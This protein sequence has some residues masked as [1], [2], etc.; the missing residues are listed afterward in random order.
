MASVHRNESYH[1]FVKNMHF[2]LVLS[3]KNYMYSIESPSAAM[4]KICRID[5]H[6]GSCNGGDEVFLLCD[7]VQKGNFKI[8]FI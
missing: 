4:L 8:S 5:R 3:E 6:A 2:F 1:V 7:R